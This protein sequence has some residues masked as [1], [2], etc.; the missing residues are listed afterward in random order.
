M[1]INVQKHHLSQKNAAK[2][3]QISMNVI[4]LIKNLILLS[5]GSV[6]KFDDRYGLDSGVQILS[7]SCSFWENLAKSYVGA[8]LESWGPHLREILDPPLLRTLRHER[9]FP[10]FLN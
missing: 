8:P 4:V 6:E 9:N 1:G 2:R 5:S 3:E 10:H 7:I